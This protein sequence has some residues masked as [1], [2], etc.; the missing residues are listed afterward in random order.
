VADRAQTAA[1]VYEIIGNGWPGRF[2]DEQLADH[3]SLG[4]DGLGLDSIEIVELLLACEEH[5]GGTSTDEL[6][7]AGPVSIGR[8]I[9]HLATS[10]AP[11]R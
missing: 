9:D 3:V 4:E 10:S 1:A 5:V 11:S 2:S 6:L 7:G 8:L